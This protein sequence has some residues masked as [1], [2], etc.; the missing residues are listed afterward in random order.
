MMRVSPL[1]ISDSYTVSH[2]RFG[3]PRGWFQEWFKASQIQPHLSFDFVPA[4]SN[5]SYSD[6]GVLRG[7]HYSLAPVGQA[8]MVTVMAGEIDD[9]VVDIRVGSPTFGQHERIR[10]NTQTGASVIIGPGLGHAFHV[11]SDTAVV[12]YMLSSEYNPELEHGVNPSCPDLAIPWNTDVP[13]SVS[14]R[15]QQMPFTTQQRENGL[16][17]FFEQ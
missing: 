11:L 7:I 1:S 8:K 6:C 2:D 5:I 12:C 4:Q 14:E 16:L 10:L 17:P 3:D 9:Y 13:F 15:D